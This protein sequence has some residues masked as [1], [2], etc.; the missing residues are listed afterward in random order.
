GMTYFGVNY[1]LSGLHS[2]AQGDAPT[3][4]N[5]VYVMAVMMVLLILGA[6]AVDRRR[7][8]GGEAGAPDEMFGFA[9]TDNVY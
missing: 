2:Y 7:S 8:W 5:W 1:F 4:P 6:Y 3:L 9:P